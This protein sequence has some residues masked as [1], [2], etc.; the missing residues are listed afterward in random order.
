[1]R[2]YTTDFVPISKST[3][4]LRH[5]FMNRCDDL[6]CIKEDTYEVM[7]AT[8]MS[9][10]FRLYRKGDH[11]T[12]I[13]YDAFHFEDLIEWAKQAKRTDK[14]SVYLFALSTSIYEEELADLDLPNLTLQAIPDDILQTYKKIFYF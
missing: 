4:D 7:G 1:M 13:L 14:I 10:Y 6:L 5:N 9:D 2:Y 8:K 11:I 3:D 12:A